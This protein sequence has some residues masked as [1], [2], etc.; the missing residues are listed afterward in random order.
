ME[1]ARILEEGIEER[2]ARDAVIREVSIS[3][4]NNEHI[5]LNV[6]WDC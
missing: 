3:A 4:T 5:P 1:H 2:D 6:I